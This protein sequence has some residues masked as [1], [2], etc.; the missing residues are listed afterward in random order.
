MGNNDQ[1]TTAQPGQSRVLVGPNLIP[2]NEVKRQNSID[3]IVSFS[4]TTFQVLWGQPMTATPELFSLIFYFSSH[5]SPA[6]PDLFRW[7]GTDQQHISC[8]VFV[9]RYSSSLPSKASTRC[10]PPVRPP[11][12]R[13][14]RCRR[15]ASIKYPGTYARAVTVQRLPCARQTQ[16]KPRRPSLP[17]SLR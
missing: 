10:E 11:A 5:R 16:E 6:Q 2:T 3:A 7:D 12:R 8:R 1:I 17:P 15:P 14:R 4:E 13:R 9:T